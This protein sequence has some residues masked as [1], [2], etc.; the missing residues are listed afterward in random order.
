MATP[1]VSEETL[2]TF[3][4]NFSS[5]TKNVL[6]QNVCR[7]TD[8]WEVCLQQEVV[9]GSKHV[10]NTK[11]AEVKPMTNQKSSGRCWI[12]ACLNMMRIPFM[13]Q[14]SI[15]D[16]EFSQTYL[17]FWDKLE[18]SNYLLD[19]YIECAKKGEQA[20]GR[21]L[22][23]LLHNPSEDGGQWD[24]LVNLI[25]KY[26]VI[27]KN[28]MH[29]AQ[30]SENSRRIGCLLNTKHREF[31][32]SLLKMVNSGCSDEEI[33][34][35]KKEMLEEIYRLVSVSLGS[36]PESITWEYYEGKDKVY[37]KV[38]PIS[39]LEFYRQ[40]VKPYA[41][42]DDKVCIVNDPRPENH[43]DKLYTVHCLNNMTAGV[44]VLYINKPAS[45]LKELAAKTLK[46]GKAVWFGCDVGKY[47]HGKKGLLDTKLL[48]FNLVFGFNANG[49]DKANRLVYGESL[50]TH[51]MLLTAVNIED[52]KTKTWRVENSWGDDNGDKGYLSMS[53]DWFSEYVYEV[54]I[55]KK[56]LSE[57]TLALLKQEPVVLP[58]WDPM[59][60]L[61]RL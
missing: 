7:K 22:S 6:A 33:Q 59:G 49:L 56:F 52:D 34:K 17:F 2:A 8:L 42:V 10:Y 12:F 26:G 11:V 43:Y 47:F 50:M 1:G 18:R 21:L 25:E 4:K 40:H 53:D 54:V 14:Y 9:Q 58:A 55:D 61:A 48:D 20:S 41:S 35:R 3:R 13:K 39:P 38:G 57:E 29:D 45:V 37:K 16:F 24:M 5:D 32:M 28:H 23:H 31:C 30:S 44:P 27:P 36:P 46:E 51:A 60:A 15:E 19:V